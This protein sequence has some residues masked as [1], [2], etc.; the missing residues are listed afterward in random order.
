MPGMGALA[1]T[2]GV[3]GVS[4]LGERGLAMM[5]FLSASCKPATL[6][7]KQGRQTVRVGRPGKDR[8]TLAGAP[9]DPP[10]VGHAAQQMKKPL[11]N[12][13]GAAVAPFTGLSNPISFETTQL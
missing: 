6:A 3:A 8:R 5:G 7:F 10:K 1:S 9:H 11:T 4:V 12:G 2:P 13:M